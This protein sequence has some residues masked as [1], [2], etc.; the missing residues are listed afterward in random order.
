MTERN[1]P[2]PL[3]AYISSEIHGEDEEIEVYGSSVRDDGK[4]VYIEGN[5][6]E[7]GEFWATVEVTGF[8][9]VLDGDDDPADVEIRRQS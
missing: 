6:F 7:H 4:S 3:A 8:G 9:L 2:H 1:R 5:H